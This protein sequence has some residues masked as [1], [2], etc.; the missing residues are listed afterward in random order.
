MSDELEFRVPTPDERPWNCPEGYIY[1]Y[2]TMFLYCRLLF[3]LSY[4]FVKYCENW[5]VAF[6][7]M[8][9]AAVCN[10]VGL[11]VLVAEANLYV[12]IEMLEQVSLLNVSPRVGR[13]YTSMKP[14]CK[15]ILGFKS[16][17]SGWFQLYFFGKINLASVA[18]VTRRYVAEWNPTMG[19]CF[20]CYVFLSFFELV[21]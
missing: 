20:G 21:F 2:E 4:Q 5:E 3:P 16:K 15:I 12:F 17:F 18:D 14:G 11:M 13:F 1:L 6:M 7:Q 9:S 8:T 19:R 10:M